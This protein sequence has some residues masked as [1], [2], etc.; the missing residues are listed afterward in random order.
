MSLAITLPILVLA[1]GALFAT[2]V[3][4]VRAHRRAGGLA[5]DLALARTEATLLERRDDEEPLRI[6]SAACA[7]GEEPLT[8]A[9]VLQNAVTAARL[10]RPAAIATRKN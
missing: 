8:I 9:M 1:V 7:S 4:A 3:L 2:T 5:D 6:W 10:R